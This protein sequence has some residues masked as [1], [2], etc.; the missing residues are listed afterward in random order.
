MRRPEVPPWGPWSLCRTRTLAAPQRTAVAATLETTPSRLLRSTV[1]PSFDSTT[2]FCEQASRRSSKRPAHRA[3]EERRV[4]CA[5]RDPANAMKLTLRS[6][7][8]AALVASG[9]SRGGLPPSPLPYESAGSPN[10]NASRSTAS[11]RPVAAGYR[12]V[13]AFQG[14]SDGAQPEAGL[15]A[16]NGALVGTTYAGGDAS[17]CSGGCGTVYRV[18]PS[19]T[20]HVLHRFFGGSDG[21]NPIGGVVEL[22]QTFYGTTVGGGTHGYGTVFSVNPAGSERVLYAFAGAPDGAKPEATLLAYRGALYGTTYGG[23]NGGCFGSPTGC[24]TA[25]RVDTS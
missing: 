8:V 15:L 4:V 23:G 22:D 24:G 14:G 6:V 12:T 19:G 3:G 18:R 5:K 21:A 9:C 11:T 1:K 17:G 16:V 25:F 13:Y 10:A 20:E 2:F 7:I